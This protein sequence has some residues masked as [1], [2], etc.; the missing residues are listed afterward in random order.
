MLVVGRNRMTNVQ[1]RP[2]ELPE[3]A[4]SVSSAWNSSTAVWL[5]R[6]V[7]TRVNR[8]GQASQAGTYATFAVS[9]FW[10]GFYPGT[11]AVAYPS[12]SRSGY[13][14]RGLTA[15]VSWCVCCRLLHLVHL[16]GRVCGGGALGAP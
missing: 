14:S 9:A 15:A 3:N 10:H 6:Y 13:G 8:P 4:R 2:V 11:V 7:Y 1:V 5:K 12:R 16:G